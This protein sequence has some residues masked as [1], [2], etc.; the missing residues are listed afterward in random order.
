LG[1]LSVIEEFLKRSDVFLKNLIEEK[2]L[3][4][5]F[6]DASAR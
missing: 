5:Y 6:V 1:I 4:D 2:G 3:T